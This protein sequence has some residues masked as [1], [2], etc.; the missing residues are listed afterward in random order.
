MIALRAGIAA[1]LL[2]RLTPAALA[3]TSAGVQSKVNAAMKN[4]KSF[5][6]TTFD[7]G[8]AYSATLVYVAPDRSRLAV[9]VSASTT[10]VVTVGNTAYSSKNGATFEKADVSDAE[11]ARS[12]PVGSMKVDAVRPDVT[13]AG[14]TYGAFDSTVPLGD[15]VT[16]TC[17]YDKRSFRLA[18]CANN[19]VTRT[20]GA[21]DDPSN[22]VQTPPTFVDAPRSGK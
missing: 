15:P 16:L 5:V 8:N 13:I 4:A 6:V 9:A 17:A 14:V 19:E 22:V 20:Y 10:D 7:P 3:E 12:L 2:C 11:K 1:L 18:R 21:Y